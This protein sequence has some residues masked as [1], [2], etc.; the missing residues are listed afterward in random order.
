PSSTPLPYTTLF[1]S[2]KGTRAAELASVDQGAPAP[3]DELLD[4]VGKVQPSAPAPGGD[5]AFV[6]ALGD[7]QFG[8]ADGDGAEGTL[9]RTLDCLERAA[10]L[11]PVYQARFG[12]GHIHLAW[13]GDH[14][15]GFSSQG[16]ANVWRTPLTLN[17]QLRQI[18]RA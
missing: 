17:E 13:L 2:R 8:K 5:H 1:R 15:E 10:A 6:V 16:G 12:I 11:V 7:M 18:G 3:I 4:L 14:I 9:R